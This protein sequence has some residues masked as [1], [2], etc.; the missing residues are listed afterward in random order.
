MQVRVTEYNPHWP[1]MFMSESEKLA[2]IFGEGLVAIHHI[3]STAVPGMAA[4]PVIDMLPVAADIERVEQHNA[5]M[6]ELGYRVMGEFGIAGRR[7]FSR[8]GNSFSCHVHIFGQHDRWNIDRH[9]A[10]RDYLRAFPA[11]AREYSELKTELARIHRD[12]R[13]AYVS[14]KEEFVLDLQATAL[15]WYMEQERP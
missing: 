14:G 5:A 3:G 1:K 6:E 2:E 12:N 13:P 9:V 11:V 7:F 4:K 15:Q 10:V 8:S